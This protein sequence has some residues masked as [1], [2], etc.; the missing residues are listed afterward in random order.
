LDE[1]AAELAGSLRRIMM[2]EVPTMAIE[3]VDF[4]KNDSA[5]Y[6]ELLANR[7]GQIPLTFDKKLYD[8]T[9]DCKCED[10]GCTRCQV[11]FT[12]KKSGPAMVYAEDLKSKNKD[13]KPVFGKTPIVELF[14]GQ[15]IEFEAT[16][17]LG[18]GK[19]H[20]KWQAAIVGFKNRTD[21][22]IGKEC[23]LCTKCIEQCA[24]KTLRVEGSK[25]VVENPFECNLCMEC[26]DVC[27]QKCIKIDPID[28]GFIFNVESVSGLPPEDIVLD[29]VDILQSKV[30]EF[31]KNLGKLK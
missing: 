8:L 7:L 2:S 22:K 25:V 29:A 31:G 5:I 14:E 24:K 1:A 4:K 26:A 18:I 13:V 27:P 10:K 28:T 23:N 15:D 20:A 17:Q 6:D 30:K 21:I 16:A 3:W 11:K 9:K 12:L 19:T